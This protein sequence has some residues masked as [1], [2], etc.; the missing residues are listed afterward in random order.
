MF[1]FGVFPAMA[2]SLTRGRY[3][4]ENEHPRFIQAVELRVVEIPSVRIQ[5]CVS[6]VVDRQSAV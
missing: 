5:R 6:R 3:M 1:S 2:L 4:E